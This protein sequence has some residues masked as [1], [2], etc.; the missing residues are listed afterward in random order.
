MNI[1]ERLIPRNMN[2]VLFWF[3]VSAVVF[4]V[5]EGISILLNEIDFR[6]MR[7]TLSFF[8]Y[9]ILP[10][11]LIWARRAFLSATKSL[12][13][14]IEFPTNDYS[15]WLHNKD[16]AI[17]SINN[18]GAFIR[19]LLT[20][21]AIIIF[22]L[23]SSH[24]LF[25]SFLATLI[26]YIFGSFVFII[27]ILGQMVIESLLGFLNEIEK[28]PINLPVFRVR[29][30]ELLKLFQ[31]YYRTAL[32]VFILVFMMM[33]FLLTTPFGTKFIVIFLV[34]LTTFYPLAL[35]LWSA[36]KIHRMM[37]S[38]KELHIDALNH[39]I[40]ICFESVKTSPSKESSENLDALLNLQKKLASEVDWP[41]DFE[42]VS[43]LLITFLIPSIN[44]GITL[45]GS[46]SK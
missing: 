22:S 28:Y 35:L 27:G 33:G 8:G 23:L 40:Q 46:F 16:E 14:V 37:L 36:Y 38:A 44:F 43:A 25:Q 4:G 20:L 15:E 45:W 24:I 19:L 34:S 26:A 10:V 29:H 18:R 5:W 32:F 42:G 13:T 12:S 17:F 3:L 39:Q 9:W 31:F 1:I 21:I 6:L 30:P 41:I 11:S 2:Y 7:V